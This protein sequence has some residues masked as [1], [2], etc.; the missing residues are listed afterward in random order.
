[1]K[2]IRYLLEAVGLGVL[3]MF[4]SLLPVAWA[5]AIGGFITRTI[6]PKTK[7]SKRALRHMMRAMPDLTKEQYR[8]AIIDMWDNLGRVICEYPHLKT[9]VKNRVELADEDVAQKIIDNKKGALCIGAHIANWEVLIPFFNEYS[10][11]QM[12][13]TYR[14]PNNKWTSKL[15]E[16]VRKRAGI[17]VALAKNDRKTGPRLVHTL[18]QN[19]YAGMLIDQKYNE[20]LNINFF[21]LQAMTNPI[22]V[23]LSRKFDVPLVMARIE[24]L[25]KARFRITV[26]PPIETKNR[27]DEEVMTEVHGVLEDWIKD[28]LGH[29]M[30]LHRRW[31][32]HDNNDKI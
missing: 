24:R 22:A 3:L 14:Q 2:T 16:H 31:G 18:K 23:R 30:W 26:M 20:G 4:L 19:G 1:M 32:N 15:L 17:T 13:L 5:S 9:I 11:I 12:A 27:T 8:I 28:K 7:A 29:W 25:P 10:G 6:G 21:G